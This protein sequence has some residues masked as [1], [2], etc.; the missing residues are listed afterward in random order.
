[1]EDLERAVASPFGG[2][3]ET[4]A[5]SGRPHLTA[6][7]H[8][9][10]DGEFLLAARDN[11]KKVC[12]IRANGVVKL[13]VNGEVVGPYVTAYCEAQE[14]TRRLPQYSNA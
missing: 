14:S 2:I 9:W 12:H 3:V 13:C 10:R 5:S 11:S 8:L 7:W 4:A 1:M 6:V